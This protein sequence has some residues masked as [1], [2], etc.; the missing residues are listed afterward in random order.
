MGKG[1]S[2]SATSRNGQNRERDHAQ[3]IAHCSLPIAGC[4][5]LR[6]TPL[7]Y[8][9]IQHRVRLLFAEGAMVEAVFQE[10]LQ[11]F[12]H[13]RSGRDAEVGHHL[14][15]IERR[16]DGVEFFTRPEV[17]DAIPP[18]RYVRPSERNGGHQPGTL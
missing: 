17:G 10:H 18:S 6:L 2:P 15:A 12:P 3:G 14:V 8:P 5:A 11:R 9:P 4:R 1:R 7:G 13:L 16:A